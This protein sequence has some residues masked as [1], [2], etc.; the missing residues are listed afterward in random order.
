MIIDFFMPILTD[1]VDLCT[2]FYIVPV[3]MLKFLHTLLVSAWTHFIHLSRAG[4][5]G[6]RLADP[7][8]HGSGF[9]H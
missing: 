4:L 1:K 8:V 2:N 9:V 7:V 5:I 3:F 6:C